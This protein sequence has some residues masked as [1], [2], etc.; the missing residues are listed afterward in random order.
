LLGI[1]ATERAEVID[2]L[3]AGL[4]YKSLTGLRQAT[5]FSLETL[6][7]WTGISP[8]TLQRRR[9]EGRFAA[10]E[11]ERI[12]RAANIFHLALGLFEG[13]A[14]A[15]R[16]WLLAPQSAL[17]DQSPLRLARTEL[18]GRQVEDLIGRLEYGVF[19]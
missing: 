17:G 13:D 2:V 6:A 14:E 8:R 12:Y 15:A 9:L 10:D 11:S 16:Q 5:G 18:G 7:D 3:A 4:A 1:R 19:S